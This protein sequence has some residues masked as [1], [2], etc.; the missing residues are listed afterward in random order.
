[1]ALPIG[2]RSKANGLAIQSNGQI[3]IAGIAAN[4][5]AKPV[6]IGRINTDGSLDTAFGTGGIVT[7]FIGTSP[8]AFDLAI[9]SNGDIVA[10]GKLWILIL[11]IACYNAADGSLDS[12]LTCRIQHRE[13]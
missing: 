5:M 6:C 3:V 2:N 11:L 12:V 9:Q 1:M 8:Q 13:L 7:T 10:V 4:D